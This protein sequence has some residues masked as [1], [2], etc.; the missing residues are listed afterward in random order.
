MQH[1]RIKLHNATRGEEI[2]VEGGITSFPEFPFRVRVVAGR[3][4]NSSLIEEEKFPDED[5]LFRF[6][7][8]FVKDR[9]RKGFSIEMYKVDDLD[10]DWLSGIG[11]NEDE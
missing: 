9:L 3:G 8:T 5:S 2:R 1:T 11:L 10:I 6:I 4:D 7:D